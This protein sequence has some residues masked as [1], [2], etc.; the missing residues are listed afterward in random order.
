M[1]P[2]LTS[3]EF[4]ELKARVEALER[5]RERPPDIDDEI[6]SCPKCGM[7]LIETTCLGSPSRSKLCPK[8]GQGY[9]FSHMEVR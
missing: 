4:E 6:E 7:R 1:W 2:F 5:E 8:C 3:K 9:G